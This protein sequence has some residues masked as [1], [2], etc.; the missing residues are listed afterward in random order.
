MQITSMTPRLIV[1][2]PDKSIGFYQE[3][4]GAVLDERYVDD[5]RVVHA[6]LSISGFSLSIAAEVAEW[7][8]LAPTTLGGS[9]VL[10]TLEVNDAREV[11]ER[12]VANGA[13][14]LVP[15][16]DRPY[17]RCEGRIQDP[18]GHLWIP[19]HKTMPRS[20]AD[21][22]SGHARTLKA[23]RLVADLSVANT[24]RST[25]FFPGFWI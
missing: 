22:L 13:R 19:T 18:F 20:D 17:G 10:V 8:L 7:G 6:A 14:V 4:L 1:T 16:K 23:T 12:M 24:T 9:A 11:A 2:N 21:Q 15:I 25:N 3:A 5:G